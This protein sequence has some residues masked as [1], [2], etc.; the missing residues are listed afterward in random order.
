M[1]Y[2]TSIQIDDDVVKKYVQDNFSVD[3]V[4]SESEILDHI[5]MDK[6]IEDVYSRKELETWAIDNGYL[7]EK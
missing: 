1:D 7:P 5:H 2:E 3:D 6:D 4:Y